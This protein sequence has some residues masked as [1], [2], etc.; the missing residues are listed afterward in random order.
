MLSEESRNHL[1]TLLPPT[2]FANYQEHLGAD[3]PSLLLLQKEV[4]ETSSK[5][6]VDENERVSKDQMSMP[7]SNDQTPPQQSQILLPE[8]NHTFFNDSHFLAALRTFQDH[9]YLNWFTDAHRAKVQEFQEGIQNGTLAAPWKDEGWEKDQ[10][11][12][13]GAGKSLEVHTNVSSPGKDVVPNGSGSC[14]NPNES[15]A[16]AG[17]MV[18]M[19]LNTKSL[20]RFLVVLLR[21]SYQR[22]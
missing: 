4:A 5:M 8:L 17:Y 13:A 6:E 1:K 11:S 22:S 10:A 7:D 21:L 20:T 18:F 2:A 9:L 12:S 3:H 14:V 15:N 19:T 16:R